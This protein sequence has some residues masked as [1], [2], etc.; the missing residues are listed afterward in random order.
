MPTA[1]GVEA[2]LALEDAAPALLFTRI[3]GSNELIWPQVR[4][5]FARAT[6]EHE[7][8]SV[9]LPSNF[10][11]LQALKGLALASMP[12]EYSPRRIRPSDFCFVVGGTTMRRTQ[13]AEE[14]W[15]V[16]D[17]AT[18][19]GDR[20][21]VL[22]AAPILRDQQWRPSFPKTFSYY[23]SLARVDSFARFAPLP[24]DSVSAI[25]NFVRECARL[26][27]YS[28]ES[29]TVA[30]IE[31]DALYRFPRT[32]LVDSALLRILSR[33]K[34]RAVFLEDAS[35]GSRSALISRLK[36]RG[37]IIIEPQHGWIGASHGAYNF[38][39]AMSTPELKR[40]LPDVLLTFGDYWTRGIRH[41][42]DVISVGKPH[43]NTMAE[44]LP[45]FDARPREVLVVSSIADPDETAEFTLALRDALPGGWRVR[46]RP[47][48]S[49]REQFSWRYP[50]LAHADGVWLDE[51]ADVYETL[52]QVRCVIGVAST[53]LYEALNMHCHVF[54]R[55][56]PF[57]AYIADAALGDRL[58]GPEGIRRIV[59]TLKGSRPVPSIA[60]EDIWKS[61]AVTNFVGFL[62]SAGLNASG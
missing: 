9:S 48:P 46:F 27:P 61:A 41:P 34:P 17:F 37:V 3:P 20:S 10:S 13:T 54:V 50:L 36:D 21:A 1:R 5:M 31:R 47:H 57:A 7:L 35:Y 51:N 15:L 18:S 44:N 11:R 33:V 12:S 55:D 22:Q 49:E 39:A 32:K 43:M 38:G 19:I 8:S 42:A 40:T 4:M 53:V 6:A 14:N 30:K 60:P 45:P 59:T 16:D 24:S 56:T 23:P 52:R 2:L 29:D 58:S 25:R 62:D 28:L 26:L